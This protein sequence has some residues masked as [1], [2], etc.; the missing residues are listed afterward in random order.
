M[1]SPRGHTLFY[2]AIVFTSF[3]VSEELV[4]T[5]NSLLPSMLSVSLSK[6]QSN[7]DRNFHI[8]FQSS[9]VPFPDPVF[10]CTDLALTVKY[11]PLCL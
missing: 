4:M 5:R 2:V 10:A 8:A 3:L 9:I 1:V 6:L 7:A 11:A